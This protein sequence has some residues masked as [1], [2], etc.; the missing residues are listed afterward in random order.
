[1]E[2]LVFAL[3]D[4]TVSKKDQEELRLSLERHKIIMEQAEDTLFEWDTQTDT[5]TYSANFEKKFG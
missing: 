2:Y 5:V 3:M 4:I 1:M